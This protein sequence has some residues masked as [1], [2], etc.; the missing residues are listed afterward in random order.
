MP[1]AIPAPGG[2]FG[3]SKGPVLLSSVRCY[4]I[5]NNLLQCN[6]ATVK[7]Q[8]CPHSMDVGVICTGTCVCMW[9]DIIDLNLF[10]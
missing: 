9:C 1:G 7:Y 6:G 4:G 2:S 5:E 3:S 8:T 10:V